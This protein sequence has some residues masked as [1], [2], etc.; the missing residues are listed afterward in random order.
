MKGFIDRTFLPGITFN[1]VEGKAKPKQLL[2]GKTARIIITA[3]TPRW[4]NNF[5]MKDPAIN[6]LKRGALKFCSIKSVKSYISPMKQLKIEKNGL[7]KSKYLVNK[8]NK[9]HSTDCIIR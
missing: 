4:Y 1:Y 8:T 9:L 2:K 3:D 6:Q 7:T 5:F